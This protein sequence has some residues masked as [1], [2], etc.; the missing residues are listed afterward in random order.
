MRLAHGQDY[1][2][3]SVLPVSNRGQVTAWVLRPQVCQKG[4]CIPVS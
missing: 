1:D 3:P 2:T 4:M